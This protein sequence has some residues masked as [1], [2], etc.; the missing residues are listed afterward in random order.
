MVLVIS[1]LNK[2]TIKIDVNEGFTLLE[3]LVALSIIATVLGASLRAVA[4]LTQNSRD[5]RLALYATWSAENRLSQ[6]RLEREWPP[7]G[8][9]QFSCSQAN[10]Q[11]ECKE[12]ILDTPN[13]A[14]RKVEVSV[15]SPLEHERRIIML[16]QIVPHEM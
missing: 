10:I 9:R 13:P 2:M 1:E 14:F 3:V 6:I 8:S 4:S 16:S 12:N 11:L 5:L 7:L 15:F